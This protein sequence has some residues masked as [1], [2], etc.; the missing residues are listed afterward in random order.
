MTTPR[1]LA[2]LVC[3]LI[4]SLARLE[5]D[6]SESVTVSVPR[7][8]KLLIRIPQGWQ[9]VMVQ[10]TPDLPPSV[11]ITALSNSVSLQITF[12]PDPEGRFTTRES[13]DRA[14]TQANQHYV[15][16]SVEKR[17]TLTQIVSTNG[18]GCYATFTDG[19]LAAA[20]RIPKGEFKNVMSGLFV[21]KRQLATFTLLTNEPKRAESAQTLKSISDVITVPE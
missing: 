9:H 10:P 15:A 6:E 8:D 2:Y 18:H 4:L 20:P 3:G 16:G 5:A 11:R 13:V 19:E 17:L 14:A 12:L 21:V 1:F 7:G